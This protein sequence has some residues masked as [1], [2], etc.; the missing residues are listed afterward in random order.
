MKSNTL[1]LLVGGS[2]LVAGTYMFMKHQEQKRADCK[3]CSNQVRQGKLIHIEAPPCNQ[4]ADDL[5]L[6]HKEALQSAILRGDHENVIKFS[7]NYER[8]TGR[9]H[10]GKI[11]A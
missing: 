10:P 2:A 1:L 9:P 8:I 6:F 4:C 5:Q 7:E 11:L 3:F